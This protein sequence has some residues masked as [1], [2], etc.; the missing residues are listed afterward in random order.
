M[1]VMEWRHLL[2][3][4]DGYQLCPGAAADE[5]GAVEAALA[6]VFPAQLREVYRASNGV[7]DR[8]G[9]W[10]VIWP[11]PEVV[12]RNGEAWSL[13]DSLVR[14]TLVGFG[15]NGTGSPFCVRRDG[16][17]G[18]FIWSA[19]DGQATPLAGTVAE[20]WVGW[21]ASTLPPH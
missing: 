2:S 16:G 9:Q 20:F 5:I 14:R 19:I 10:F 3:A 11:L 17:S 8:L 1:V 21:V 15:D 18:V 12:A 7:F 4:D 6:A 13:T